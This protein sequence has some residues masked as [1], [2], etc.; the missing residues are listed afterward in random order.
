MN[1]IV[2]V[3]ENFNIGIDNKLLF[4]IKRDMEFFKTKTLNNV[5]IMGRKTLE[6]LPNSA[7]L[8]NRI[9]IVMTSQCDFSGCICVKDIDALFNLLKDYN[10]NDIY[11]I[12]GEQIYKLLLPYCETAYIT[13]VY[14]NKIGDS[15]FPNIDK[16][17]N[18]ELLQSSEVFNENGLEFSFNIYKNKKVAF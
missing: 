3:D 17:D 11:V 8:K 15:K 6:S 12:G 5:V 18:W 4:D 13:K 7:P 10:T 1:I 14:S 9:N 16:L 2:C